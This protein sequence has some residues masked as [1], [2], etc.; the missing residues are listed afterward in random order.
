MARKST[1]STRKRKST[2]KNDRDDAETEDLIEDASKNT[3][4]KAQ[5][6]TTKDNATSSAKAIM[7][8]SSQIVAAFHSRDNSFLACQVD[9][10]A[11]EKRLWPYFV[12]CVVEQREGGEPS[13][14]AALAVA[15]LTNWDRSDSGRGE[16]LSFVAEDFGSEDLKDVT[17]SMRTEAFALLLKGMLPPLRETCR[18][19]DASYNDVVSIKTQ[20][21]QFLITSYSSMELRCKTANALSDRVIAG[22]LV[23][24]AG[25]RLWSSVPSRK[26][27][28][29]LRRD[30]LLRKRYGLFEARQSQKKEESDVAFLPAV[31]K[32]VLEAVLDGS[33]EKENGMDTDS[34]ENNES[35]D[36]ANKKMYISKSLELIIDLLSYPQTRSNVAPYL[37][38]HQFAVLLGLSTLYH[39][40]SFVLFRQQVDMII[41]SER[42]EVVTST[43]AA[44]TNEEMQNLPHDDIASR[45]IYQRAHT[46]QKLLHRHHL[47][48][49]SEVIFAGVGR[50]TDPN[51]LR[52]KVALW[53]EDTLYDVCYRSRLVDDNDETSLGTTE[54]LAQR[55][56]CKRRELLTSILLYHHSSRKS[57]AV[58]LASA[59]LYPIETLLWDPHSV[60]PGYQYGASPT[61]SNIMESLSLPKLNARFLSAG[62]YLLRNFRL[63]R[64]ESAYEIRGDLVD[65]VKRMMPSVKADG[66]TNDSN[67]YGGATDDSANKDGDLFAKTK[68]QGW[69]RMG[70]ELKS[71]KEEKQG[72]RL[73]RVDPPKLGER[74]PANVI[75]EVVLDLYHCATSLIAEW[76]EIGEFDNLFLVSVDASKMSGAPAPMMTDRD[77]RVPDEEDFTFP[78]R[79]GIQAV[80]GC[81][82]L[83]VRDEAG[84]VLSDPALAYE[85]GG[86][87]EPKGKRR[88]LRVA[89]DPAQYAADAAGHG[90]PLGIDVYDTFNLVVRRHGRE[91]NFKA[92]LETIRGLMRGGA[93]SMYRSIPSWLMPVLLGY[94]GDPSAANY[95]SPKMISF[96]S[97]TAGVNSPNAA[98]DYGDTFIDDAHLKDSFVGCDVT[99]DGTAVTDAAPVRGAEQGRK[100]YRVKVI[101]QGQG[102]AKVEAETYPFPVLYNGNPI[103]FTPVQVNAIRSGLSPGLTTIIGPPGTG[104]T[105][106][107]VQI[108]ANLYHSFPTQRTVIVTHS[109][110]ALNDIFDKVM[111]R[112][113]VDERYMLRLGSGERNL[114]TTSSSSHDFTK[115]GRVLHV[116]S[117]RGELLEKVQQ[118]SE[119]LGVSSAAE[120]GANGAPSYTCETAEYF[121]LHHVKKRIEAF[122]ATLKNVEAVG[123]SDNVINEFPF[124]KYFHLDEGALIFADDANRK[125]EEVNAVFKELSEYRPIELLR[126]QRQRTDY[127]LIKQARIVAMT[128]THAA[129]A[130]AQLV[131]LGFHYDNIIMEEAGQMLDVETFIPLL[132][133][134]GESDDSAS[135]HSRLKRVC[136]IGDHNQLP[137]VVKNDS[138]SKYS[139]YDQS[140]F[141]RLIRLGVPSI[142]LNKQGRARTDIAKLY[143][144]RYDNLGDLDHV[145]TKDIFKRANTGLAHTYQ[146]I[147]VDDFEGRGESTPTAYFYQNLGE[148]EY[149]VALFQYMVLIGYPPEKIS[150][151]TTYNGQKELLI[152]ILS[153]RCGP[154]TP[155]AGMTPGAISTV[156]QYQGQQNDYIILSLVRT[157]AVGHLRDV[158]RL[159]VA[160]SRARLGLY[161]L[162][163]Q[164]VFGNC[165]ELRHT[166]DQYTARPTKLQLVQ[167]E[168]FPTNRF[169]GE[170]IPKECL[171]EVD[172]VNDL[173]TLVHSMQQEYV[174]SA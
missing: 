120:R 72:L 122:E 62:D 14:H 5:K 44:S 1:S 41:D 2:S 99:V 12:R 24:L 28:L 149:A 78:Q 153:Q 84:V 49:T 164:S 115:T 11:V 110:A 94:G 145:T 33:W 55:L 79:Y 150:I 54:E 10:G 86:R 70:L 139:H 172:T 74:V 82:V 80:R 132:L 69:A 17:P 147:N 50:L 148:A 162:C 133:Q 102:K 100:K 75:A 76:D 151:L 66:Y 47:R 27:Y 152:D 129:I 138:F 158:R 170:A 9:G 53:T 112:G 73:I 83:E 109:N 108:I 29:E 105:D 157:K 4:S 163:R 37:A 21:V 98:L 64:L 40:K 38:S 144:W 23:D 156:D 134:R 166:M 71:N 42:M 88:Y 6:T 34:H 15:I 22:P 136:L 155:L 32:G 168:H 7:E 25:L 123:K 77:R 114:Q 135:A 16:K 81:M 30:G 59:P 67:Y 48:E 19:T 161:V 52:G 68:F 106:V 90:S 159:V 101:D 56:G 91:N 167:G 45:T 20:I 118:L 63:F 35:T 18:E 104:K 130:R 65:V 57:D 124:Q 85:E 97:K 126:S 36:C 143:S 107:A 173:G 46:L 165:H 142:E 125:V 127:L 141:A 13:K 174:L 103:R 93:M 128:C 117:R 51:W 3:P 121:Y 87:P 140:L 95:L 8:S 26:R 137:P 171:H 39:D 160:V 116:L 131:E 89:L 58:L 60:P 61:S 96:A 154:G 111:S 146:I 119:S 92:V 113:D 31:V 43:T 169:V